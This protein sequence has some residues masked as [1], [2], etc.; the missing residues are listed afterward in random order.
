MQRKKQ[1]TLNNSFIKYRYNVGHDPDS[2]SSS[3]SVA[4]EEDALAIRPTRYRTRFDPQKII[5]LDSIHVS[6]RKFYKQHVQNI[7]LKNIEWH[8]FCHFI[9]LSVGYKDKKH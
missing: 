5:K 6:L 3:R 2:E 7:S 9:C 4:W 8:L 1:E